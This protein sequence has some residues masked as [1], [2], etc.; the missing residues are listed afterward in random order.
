[1]NKTIYIN[2]IFLAFMFSA[3]KN[4]VPQR[5]LYN[6]EFNWHITIPEN[7]EL[8][9]TDKM[10]QMQNR[11]E[12]AIEE[13][14]GTEI[15]NQATNIFFFKS[16]ET[17]YFE[18]NRQPYDPEID[19]DYL[20]MCKVV[21]EVIYQTFRE[22]MPDI[23]IDSTSYVQTIDGLDFQVFN[24]IITYPNNMTL[25]GYMFSRLFEGNSE[26]AVNIM[27]TDEKK[28][29]QMLQAWENSTFSEK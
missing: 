9:K 8:V 1:M 6:K 11:G 7:F 16:G 23:R 19:G 21:N 13:T 2:L 24:T 17:N 5:N 26:F 22:Q 20:E 25:H 3:C 18:A 15:E 10:D 4:K 12:N 29:E 28:G 14:I 27:Y